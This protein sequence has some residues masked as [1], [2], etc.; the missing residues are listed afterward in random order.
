MGERDMGMIEDF[1]LLAAAVATTVT[2][3]VRREHG[4]APRGKL[5]PTGA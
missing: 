1:G 3:I 2:T 4:G 5:D